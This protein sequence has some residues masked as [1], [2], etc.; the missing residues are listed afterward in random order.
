ML[1]FQSFMKTNLSYKWHFNNTL[2]QV[3]ELPMHKSTNEENPYLMLTQNDIHNNN[4]IYQ[5]NYNNDNLVSMRQDINQFN[6]RNYSKYNQNTVPK[7]D[8]GYYYTYKLANFTNFGTI[9]CSA[10]NNIGQSGTCLY[11][12][13]IAGT[14]TSIYNELIFTL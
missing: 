3:T 2:E 4:Q 12:I 13:L 1:C 9:S 10:I 5:R 11:H 7:F 6:K 8:P 14:V